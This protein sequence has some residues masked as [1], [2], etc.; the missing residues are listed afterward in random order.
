MQQGEIKDFLR[1]QI[2]DAKN[3]Y[4]RDIDALSHEQLNASPGGSARTP[5]DFTYE[6]VFVNRRIAKRLRGETPEP[7]PDNGWIKAPE[8]FRNKDHA[9]NEVST[10]MDEILS[11]WDKLDESQLTTPIVMASGN[12]TSALG[13]GH[14]ASH[15]ASYHGAQLNYIQ[16]INGDEE[17]H[18]AQ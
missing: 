13:L 1:K 2:E 15:H 3:D 8:E 18:W 17:V 9:K 4:V 6:V 10:T 7:A 12:T 5:Y 14:M 16:A 11:A